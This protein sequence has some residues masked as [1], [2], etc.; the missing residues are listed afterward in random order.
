MDLL[1]DLTFTYTIDG[2]PGDFE[3]NLIL[4]PGDRGLAGGTE[5]AGAPP[6]PGDFDPAADSLAWL[7]EFEQTSGGERSFQRR[8]AAKEVVDLLLAGD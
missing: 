2:E 7:C 8:D 1:E 5:A 3:G 6:A 4:D